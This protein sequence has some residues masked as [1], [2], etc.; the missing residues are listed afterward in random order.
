LYR[1]ASSQAVARRAMTPSLE[2]ARVE[3]TAPTGRAVCCTLRR[4]G[5]MPRFRRAARSCRCRQRPGPR[6]P[7]AKQLPDPLPARPPRCK[8]APSGRRRAVG[9]NRLECHPTPR[10]RPSSG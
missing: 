8:C 10:W 9:G 2:A 5:R 3:P 6:L 4:P 7:H 1:P